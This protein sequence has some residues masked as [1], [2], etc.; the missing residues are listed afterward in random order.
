MIF[1]IGSSLSLG[2]SPRIAYE[3]VYTPHEEVKAICVNLVC[4]IAHRISTRSNTC[5]CSNHQNDAYSIPPDFGV[6]Q[7]GGMLTAHM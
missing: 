2:C 1:G 7:Q 3:E 4:N 5:L 6:S